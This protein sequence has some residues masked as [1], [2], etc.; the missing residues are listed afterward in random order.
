MLALGLATAA[1]AVP[2]ERLLHAGRASGAVYV[3]RLASNANDN[4]DYFHFSLLRMDSRYW[5]KG[6]E[7]HGQFSRNE[8]FVRQQEGFRSTFR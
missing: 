6:S 8:S 2:G 1:F 3:Y 7:E 4:A 5:L